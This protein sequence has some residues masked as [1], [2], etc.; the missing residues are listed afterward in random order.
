[1][2]TVYKLSVHVWE[3]RNDCQGVCCSGL[4]VR[5]FVALNLSKR[6]HI[7][8]QVIW[9]SRGLKEPTPRDVYESGHVS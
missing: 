7:R 3:T 9:I 6:S 8:V 5:I 2:L 4:R 1:V